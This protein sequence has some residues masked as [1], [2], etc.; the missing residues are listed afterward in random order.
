MHTGHNPVAKGAQEPADW[1]EV[2][3]RDIK[4]GNIFLAAPLSKTGR[5]IPVCKLGDFGVAVPPEYR[6]LR[7]PEDMRRA[8]T[9]GWR[10]PEQQYYED[11]VHRRKLSSATNI[12]AVGRVM[13]ALVE[14]THGEFPNQ[15]PQVLYGDRDNGVAFTNLQKKADFDKIH[16]SMLYDIIF[17]CLKPVPQDRVTAEDLLRRIHSHIHSP[18]GGLPELEEGDVLEYSHDLRWAR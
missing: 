8:G 3:H 6:P 16:G 1:T 10:A 15:L 5:G 18:L 4:P 7:N 12:W 11:A 17:D 13:L 9:K 14:L 2:I